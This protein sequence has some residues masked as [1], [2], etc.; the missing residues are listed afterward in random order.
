[1]TRIQRRRAGADPVGERRDVKLNPL[2]SVGFARTIERLMRRDSQISPHRRRAQ[3]GESS[4]LTVRPYESR[5]L[6]ERPLA[7]AFHEEAL[8]PVRG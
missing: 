3:A 6:A 1:M 4:R 2:A 5:L 7:I 8:H